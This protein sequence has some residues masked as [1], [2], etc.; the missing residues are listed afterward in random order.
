MLEIVFFVYDI[1]GVEVVK[2]FGV[3]VLYDRLGLKSGDAHTVKH[4]NVR[5]GLLQI[6]PF[7]QLISSLI[8]RIDSSLIIFIHLPLQQL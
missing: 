2:V 5:L 7:L 8:L 1:I 4:P 6:N 3:S